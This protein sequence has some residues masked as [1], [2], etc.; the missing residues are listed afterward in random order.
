M[1]KKYLPLLAVLL[2]IGL[3]IFLFKGRQSGAK[4]QT[5]EFKSGDIF[6]EPSSIKAK[7][8]QTLIF[9]VQNSGKHTFVIDEL[10]FKKELPEGASEFKLEVKKKGVFTYYCDLPGHRRGGQFGTLFVE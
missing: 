6:F 2:V 3:V 4:T 9:K 8:G 10:N 7:T 5:V 1:N